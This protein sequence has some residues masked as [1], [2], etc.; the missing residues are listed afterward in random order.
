[1]GL[2]LCSG[3]VAR[4]LGLW[5]WTKDSMRLLLIQYVG[6]LYCQFC[7]CYTCEGKQVSQQGEPMK[8][9]QNEVSPKRYTNVIHQRG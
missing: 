9:V 4:A 8:T 5:R 6:N 3:G 7:I 2:P 1:M